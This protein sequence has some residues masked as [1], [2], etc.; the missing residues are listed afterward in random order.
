MGK[1]LYE[2]QQLNLQNKYNSTGYCEGRGTKCHTA[3]AMLVT[4]QGENF[5]ITLICHSV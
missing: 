1:L 5:P 3:L 2:H 4:L